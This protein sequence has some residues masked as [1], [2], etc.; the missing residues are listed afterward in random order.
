MALVLVPIDCWLI[1]HYAFAAKCKDVTTVP[2]V[3]QD[4]WYRFGLQ[5]IMF[6]VDRGMIDSTGQAVPEDAGRV[7]S[8]SLS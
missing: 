4:L 3:V 7:Y 2:E 6:V 8:V 5:S 1:A